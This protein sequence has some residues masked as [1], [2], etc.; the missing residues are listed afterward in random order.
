MIIFTDTTITPEIKLIIGLTDVFVFW[1]GNLYFLHQN[2]KKQ[3]PKNLKSI[4]DYETALKRWIK[5]SNPFRSE[6]RTALQ[7][8]KTFDKKQKILIAFDNSFQNIST[9]TEAYLLT[10]IR[11]LLHRIMILN[12]QDNL[13]IHRAYLNLILHQ[14]YKILLQYDKFLIAVFQTED[15]P[16]PCLEAVTEAIQDMR[17]TI[18]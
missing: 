8:L 9:E 16:L 13:Q 4:E 10:N 15:S 6:I 17:K 18:P 7:Q 1:A 5:K 11:K 14:N 2:E 12:F 3:F